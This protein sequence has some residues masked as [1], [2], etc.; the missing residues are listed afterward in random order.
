MF[1][2]RD[3]KLGGLPDP[4]VGGIRTRLP[5]QPI[6]GNA[7]QGIEINVL[8]AARIDHVVRR[9]SSRTVKGRDTAVATEVMES[10]LGPELIRGEVRFSLDEAEL[11][12]GD[13][14]V[15]VTP[16]PADR[17]IAFADTC[18]LGSNLELNTSA[19]T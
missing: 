2:S 9:V 7:F 15:Q 12:R 11:I 3:T 18:K 14:V 17:A 13:H 4:F 19:V 16:A 8:E 5:A 10:T 6:E 1:P